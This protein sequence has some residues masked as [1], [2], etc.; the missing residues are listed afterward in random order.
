GDARA[1]ARHFVALSTNTKACGEFGI[2]PE[3][4]FAFWDWVGGR[5]SMWSAIGLPIALAAGMDAFDA[6][7]AGAYAMDRHFQEAPLDQSLPVILALLGIW[8]SNFLGAQTY[9]VVPYD[10]RLARLPAWLQQVDMESN[11]KS[12][13][14]DGK[15]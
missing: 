1:V 10:Q 2:P 12:V 14:R 8:Y 7:R 4:M 6:L 15:A 13:G 3:N 5:Y 11:G 9:T